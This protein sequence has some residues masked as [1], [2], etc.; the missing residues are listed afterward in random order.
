M[1]L[2]LHAKY[3]WNRKKTFCGRT[4]GYLRPTLLGRLRRVDLKGDSTHHHIAWMSMWCWVCY[5]LFM[6]FCG[7]YL[8][9]ITLCINRSFNVYIC[10]FIGRF[11][12]VAILKRLEGGW[13]HL[14][15]F[16]RN[17]ITHAH[18]WW[19]TWSIAKTKSSDFKTFRHH[20]CTETA[21]FPLSV[22]YLLNGD[23]NFM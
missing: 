18:K 12:Y 4:D 7:F 6:I 20:A 10:S 13:K 21:V 1:D 5:H 22:R 19:N 14:E 9:Q 11:K 17:F 15:W 23:L 2:Y 8:S 16:C 3:H